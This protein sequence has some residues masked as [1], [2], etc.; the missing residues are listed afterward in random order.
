VAEGVESAV[1][2]KVLREMGCDVAQGFRVAR[3]MPGPEATQWL[4]ERVGRGQ[5][6][7][8]GLRVV[9]GTELQA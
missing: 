8:A 4:D 1:S 7:R 5:P 3:P 2:W 9:G 6:Q